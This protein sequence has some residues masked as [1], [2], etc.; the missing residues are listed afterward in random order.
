MANVA[1]PIFALVTPFAE[2]DLAL[3][4]AALRASL[5]FLTDKVALLRTL[6]AHSI[7]SLTPACVRRASQT[8]S[9]AARR[10]SFLR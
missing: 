2:D 6:F 1:G 10:A 5:Q 8:W 7:A 4:E 9:A 3:D